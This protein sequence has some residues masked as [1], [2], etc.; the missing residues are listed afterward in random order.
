MPISFDWSE[1]I[2]SLPVNPI[3]AEW[4]ATRGQGV[5]VA[6]I[7]T[8]VNFTAASLKYL[9]QAGRKFFT[10]ADGFS[11]DKLTGQDPVFDDMGDSNSGHGTLY[12][13]LLAGKTPDTP[14]PPPDADLVTGIANAAEFYIIKARDP[15]VT[16]TITN[17][18]DALELSAKLGIEI[19]ILGQ[20]V[21]MTELAGEGL[22][23]AELDRVFGLPGVKQMHIFA[24]LEN[25]SKGGDW[26]NITGGYFP[27]LRPEVFN[28]AKLPLVYDRVANVIQAKPVQFL[29]AGFEGKLLSKDGGILD[30]KAVEPPVPNP[31]E[32]VAFSNS[33]AVAIVGGIA[34]L[35]ASFFKQQNGGAMPDRAQL[36]QLLAA[37][38]Q[39]IAAASSDFSTP[40]LF[41]KF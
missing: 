2:S 31:A 39:Q 28:V 30:L 10:G 14:P 25:R 15:S 5:K 9:N 37:H 38:S 27:N 34:V 13:S 36:T 7:D 16:S 3:P 22:T 35:A 17:L 21:P 12:A 19:A 24:A 11:V 18:K 40:A 29:A 8:G 1:T 41:N 23:P 6:F 20:C 33:G 4:L 32:E 26:N